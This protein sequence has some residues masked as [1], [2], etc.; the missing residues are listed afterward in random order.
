MTKLA[1]ITPCSRPW[2]LDRIRESICFDDD[3]LHAWIIVHDTDAAASFKPHFSPPSPKIVE[4]AAPTRA[5]E[6]HVGGGNHQRNVGLDLLLSPTPDGEVKPFDGLV[7]F[8]DDDNIVHPNFWAVLL[9][10]MR[11]DVR[12]RMYSFDQVMWSSSADAAS[13]TKT[14]TR[15]RLRGDNVRVFAIDTAQCV[16]HS[17]LILAAGD[18][19][20]DTSRL[21][22]DGIFFQTI[23][24]DV[25]AARNQHKYFDDG[26][27]GCYYNFLRPPL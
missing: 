2:N 10:R 8:L 25:C 1:I 13:S 24:R 15:L 22:A 12:V 21:E 7:Y 4:V 26:V 17:R 18:L 11:E 20:W 6:G 5:S 23:A 16:V 3:V 14:Q 27:V 9:P 19:R